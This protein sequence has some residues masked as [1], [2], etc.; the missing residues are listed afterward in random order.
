MKQIDNVLLIS[1]GNKYKDKVWQPILFASLLVFG[2]GFTM[3]WP[4]KISQHLV[5]SAQLTFTPYLLT[6][7]FSLKTKT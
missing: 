7:L 5:R 1:Q 4:E 6:T 2:C 3:C